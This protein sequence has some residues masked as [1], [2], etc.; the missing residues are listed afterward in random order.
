[1]SPWLT[2]MMGY[3]SA[4]GLSLS[5]RSL[6]LCTV[7]WQPTPSLPCGEI[8][9]NRLR[10]IYNTL[11]MYDLRHQPRRQVGSLLNMFRNNDLLDNLQVGEHTAGYKGL[12]AYN[13]SSLLCVL[14]DDTPA[15]SQ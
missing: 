9:I 4:R 6:L 11:I 1:M 5:D 3:T 7:N 14:S 2:R 10:N 15:A 13:L 8:A 12:L